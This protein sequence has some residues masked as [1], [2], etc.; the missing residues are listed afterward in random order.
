MSPFLLEAVSRQ[1]LP[2]IGP[3]PRPVNQEEEE[4]AEGEGGPRE[5]GRG[6]PEGLPE[7]AEEEARRQEE[8]PHHGVVEAASGTRVAR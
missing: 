2:R 7:E 1:A 5:E 3:P 4:G 6:R 8:D